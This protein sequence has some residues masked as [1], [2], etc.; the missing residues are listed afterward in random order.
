M[1]RN[2]NFNIRKLK[3]KELNSSKDTKLNRNL[4][5]HKRTTF[6]VGWRLF[7]LPIRMLSY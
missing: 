1:K 5:D 6:Q 4:L 2:K 3:Q 7:G